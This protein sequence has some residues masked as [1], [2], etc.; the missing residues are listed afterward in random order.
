MAVFFD[1][2]EPLSGL[3]IESLPYLFWD[4]DLVFG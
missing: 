1:D 3:E 4:Y 2:V